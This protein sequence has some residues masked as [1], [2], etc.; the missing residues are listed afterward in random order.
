MA[1]IT[2]EQAETQLAAALDN[3][4]RVRKV[5][6]TQVSSTTGGR[7]TVFPALEAAQKEV[8]Y[9]DLKVKQL[10]RGH[11]GPVFLRAVPLG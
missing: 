10:S 9:W 4:T 3:L 11:G 1:G 8:E 2:R 6:E 5:Q 7:R